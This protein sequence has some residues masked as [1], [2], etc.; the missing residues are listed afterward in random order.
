MIELLEKMHDKF[1]CELGDIEKDEAIGNYAYDL[2][3]LHLGNSLSHRQ[4][5]RADAVAVRA[6]KAAA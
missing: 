1:R 2:A 5:D 4:P 3:T 6:E